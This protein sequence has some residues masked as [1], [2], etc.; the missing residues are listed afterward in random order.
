MVLI[1]RE[2]VDAYAAAAADDD[3]CS[4]VNFL[5]TLYIFFSIFVI[6]VAAR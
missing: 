1:F 2:A 4:I 3:D 6:V 5:Y